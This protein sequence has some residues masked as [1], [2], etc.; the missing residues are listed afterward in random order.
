MP[1]YGLLL[2]LAIN[3]SIY[4]EDF[5]DIPD[6]DEYY[7]EMTG[8]LHPL[9]K[10]TE[11]AWVLSLPSIMQYCDFWED[12]HEESLL[13]PWMLREQGKI[14][15]TFDDSSGSVNWYQW[16]CWDPVCVRPALRISRSALEQ[17]IAVKPTA[18]PPSPADPELT[19][20]WKATV[21]GVTGYYR[22]DEDGY[23][24]RVGA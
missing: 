23:H 8:R 10:Q 9:A 15:D 11:T 14:C 22:F 3:G 20:I 21:D 1:V 2:K 24:M 16:Y 19:G 6:V 17:G 13:Q 18:V 4:Y 5:Y 12:M 7:D